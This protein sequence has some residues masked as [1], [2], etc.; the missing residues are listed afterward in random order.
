MEMSQGN[1]L[2]SYPKQICHS[3]LQKTENSRA[4]PVGGVEEVGRGCRGVNMVQIFCIHG[5]KWKNENCWKYFRN[6]CRRD[7]GE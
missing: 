6:G 7:K 3:F 1:S 4:V 5:C 2:Y